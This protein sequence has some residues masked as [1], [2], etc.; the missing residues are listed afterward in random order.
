MLEIFKIVLPVFLIIG[1]GYIA[2]YRNAFSLQQASALMRFATQFAIPCLLFMAISRLDL[3]TVFKSN[4]LLPFYISALINFIITTTSAWLFFK[5]KPG[6]S[7][8]IGFTALFSNSV[9]IGIAIVELAYGKTALEVAF[10]II[11]IHAPFCYILG[12]VSM[13]FCRSDGL[14]IF[15]TLKVAIKQIFNNALTQG[16]ILGFIVNLSGFQLLTPINTAVELMARASIPAALF[17]LGATLVS[18]KITANLA[19]TSMITFN[20]LILH[21]S[22]AYAIGRFGFNLSDDILTVIVIM[23]AMPPGINAYIFATMY[24]RSENIAASAVLSATAI[25]ILSIS[26]WLLILS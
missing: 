10:A 7:V 13:E 21:P 12:I 22:L 4:I 14:N 25:S 17:G 18:Y 6:H 8:A 19:E 26:M 15:E 20:K 5:Q 11:A 23:A 2:G 24:Q 3:T 16:L 9:L 1:A